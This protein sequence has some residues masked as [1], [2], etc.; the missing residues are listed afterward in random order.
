MEIR[1]LDDREDVRELARA[2]GLAWRRAYDGILPN[3]AI[4]EVPVELEGDGLERWYEHY[5]A[6]DDRVLVADV[7]GTVRG[8]AFFRWEETKPFVG[9]DEAGL[10]EIYVHPDYW[11][12][13]IGSVLLERGLELLP[14]DVEALKLEVLAGNDLG[15]SFYEA[16][17]FE[18]V[19][20]S[21][22]EVG[23]TTVEE[24][25]YSLEL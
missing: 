21:S 16:R 7:D 10:K 20:T 19:G 22:T 8:Y 17:G 1:H 4:E 13:G 12:Q 15:R 25:I 23:T 3:D 24:A 9:P 14:P 11:G 18:R 6:H 5:A 2:H